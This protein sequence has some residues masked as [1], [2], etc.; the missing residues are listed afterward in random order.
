M[1]I[2][3][4]TD[5]NPLKFKQKLKYMKLATRGFKNV[6]V[7]DEPVFT[8][9]E[10][11]RDKCFECQENGG[12]KVTFYAGSDRVESYRKLCKDLLKK[13]QDRGELQDVELEV[14]EA[15]E[16]GT[17]QSYSATKMREHVRDDDL[18][19]FVDHCPFGT[20][21][22]NE[23]YGTQMFNDIK[24]VYL[25]G[26]SQLHGQVSSEQAYEVVKDM[27]KKVS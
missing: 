1:T 2:T 21:E 11:I 16:R 8:I 14:V 4:D 19:S 7:S 20:E 12:G 6:E 24:A 18:V 23:K 22:D 25:K 5:K 13:Y 26:S 17:F 10:F 9:Y 15:M 3:S 27:A